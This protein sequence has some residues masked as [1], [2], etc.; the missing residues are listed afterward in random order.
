[1]DKLLGDYKCPICLNSLF[2]LITPGI[3]ENK[4]NYISPVIP[5]AGANAE[6]MATDNYL[7]GDNIGVAIVTCTCSKC[8]YILTFNAA[9]I[10]NIFNGE[11]N[12]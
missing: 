1:M 6:M 11:K 3:T 8:G 7:Y 10:K 5:Y 2:E 9:M 12:G 4:K